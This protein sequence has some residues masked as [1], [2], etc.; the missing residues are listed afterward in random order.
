[1]IDDIEESDPTIVQYIEALVAGLSTEILN[2]Y[3]QLRRRDERIEKLQSIIKQFGIGQRSLKKTNKKTSI[4]RRCQNIT[5]F[6]EYQNEAV[7]N[8]IDLGLRVL[9]Q[10]LRE[11][12]AWR[13]TAM[14]TL[15]TDF[16]LENHQL[17]RDA[18]HNQNLGVMRAILYAMNDVTHRQLQIFRMTV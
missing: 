5:K 12:N 17:M 8:S 7:D 15:Q 11:N 4:F 18:D 6:I 9:K 13:D 2:K 10:Q 14:S 3:H 1:M 16:A